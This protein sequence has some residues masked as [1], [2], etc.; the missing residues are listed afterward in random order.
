MAPGIP[1]KKML[2]KALKENISMEIRF[3][4]RN[5]ALEIDLFFDNTRLAWEIIYLDHEHKIT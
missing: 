2:A 5:Y 4:D 1:F 3:D